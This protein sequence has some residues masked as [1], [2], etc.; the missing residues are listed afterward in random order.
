MIKPVI[1]SIV[2]IA[3]VNLKA[4][5]VMIEN[6]QAVTLFNVEIDYCEENAVSYDY[7]DAAGALWS[8]YARIDSVR[9]IQYAAGVNLVN[10]ID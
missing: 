6:D 2:K 5:M 3:A 4:G 1:G 8:G 10:L 7:K 9:R